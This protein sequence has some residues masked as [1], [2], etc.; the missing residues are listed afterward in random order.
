MR[1]LK[2]YDLNEILLNIFLN[3]WVSKSEHSNEAVNIYIKRV[4][5]S[6]L[7]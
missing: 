3:L 5:R 1:R 6:V 4:V 2:I 7:S